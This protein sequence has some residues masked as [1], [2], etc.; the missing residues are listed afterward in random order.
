MSVLE[1]LLAAAEVAGRAVA[2]RVP[3]LRA[4]ATQ[5]VRK[6]P[7]D[8][9]P[10]SL[11]ELRTALAQLGVDGSRDLLVHASWSG[12][13]VLRCKPSDLVKLLLDVVGTQSTLLMPAH[14][15]EKLEDGALVYDV[16]KTPTRM[17]MLSETFRRMPDVRR[18]PV[19]I[20]PVIARGPHAEAY[21]RDSRA[22]SGNTP[23]GRG[24]PWVELCERG[25]LEV[26]LGVDFVRALT[27]LHCAF[28][29]LGDD[30]PIRDYYEPIDALVV[31]S[32]VRERWHLRH[33]RR[34]LE[35]HLATFAFRKAAL[36]S[37]TVRVTNLKGIPIAVVDAKRFLAWHLPIARA[38]GMPYWGFARRRGPR[39]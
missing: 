27:L 19:P 24:T 35:R 39:R 32:G 6:P 8:D 30:N 18:G 12:L 9:V 3:E 34:S 4:R 16:N 28:D 11:D 21:T 36:A 1:Q 17:G 38:I 26:I 2:E 13:K 20:A 23:W 25:G 14:P 31:E 22:S 5:F 7:V 15:V 33:Q 29:L 37:G 10:V